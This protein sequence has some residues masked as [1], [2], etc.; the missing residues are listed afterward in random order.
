MPCD[1]LLAAIGAGLKFDLAEDP[2]AVE[3]QQLLATESAVDVT[4]KV[5][6]LGPTHPLHDRV[7]DVVAAHQGR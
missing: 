7:V 6:G 3:L 2:E 4:E 5:T 1:G